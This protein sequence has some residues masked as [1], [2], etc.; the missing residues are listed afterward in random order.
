MGEANKRPL[1]SLFGDFFPLAQGREEVT[2]NPAVPKAPLLPREGVRE[3]SHLGMQ[4]GCW[5]DVLA[6]TPALQ[7]TRETALLRG[8]T[9]RFVPARNHSS[10]Y[11]EHL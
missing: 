2:G 9:P 7:V 11:M 10:L 5:C 8:F 3:V 1:D 4:T 6:G